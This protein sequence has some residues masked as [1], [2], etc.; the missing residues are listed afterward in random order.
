M[1]FHRATPTYEV[2]FSEESKKSLLNLFPNSGNGTGLV[3]VLRTG[4]FDHEKYGKFKIDQK[5]LSDMVANFKSNVRGVD[6]AIDYFHDSDKEAAGWVKDLVLSDDKSE[7]WAEIEW[8]PRAQKKLG[9]REIRYFSADFAF[10]WK[11]PE[12]G[13]VYKNVLF[14][15]GLT[16]R[17]FI[18]DMDA[19]VASENGG[20]EVDEKL[21][22]LQAQV[23]ALTE[24]VKAQKLA[25]NGDEMEKLKAQ[26]KELEEKY[27]ALQAKNQELMDAK[28]LAEETAKTDKKKSEF[29]L[30]LSEGKAVAAQEEAYLKGDM[31]EFIKLAQPLNPK[32]AG[33]SEG[34]TETKDDDEIKKL[35]EQKVK[36]SEGK[37][38]FRD[39]VKL[40]KKENK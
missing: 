38:S 4:V 5:V 35:A 18:K 15:G 22:E 8:T 27:S 11:N 24:V 6:L 34:N 39:A 40:V 29:K 3:Q 30:L 13:K 9:E 10:E 16:N 17:P 12:T 1:I 7:L 21:K 2:K 33:S 31:G 28:K 32:G 36:E 20:I 23:L 26:L 19:I 25:E 14:G 37:L